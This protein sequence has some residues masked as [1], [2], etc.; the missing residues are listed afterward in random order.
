MNVRPFHA[1]PAS[2]GSQHVKG[3]T[4]GSAG[5]GF[6]QRSYGQ[7]ILFVI[8][9]MTVSDTSDLEQRLARQAEK[10]KQADDASIGEVIE[11]VKA[12]A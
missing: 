5:L 8:E 1:R 4:W 9:R 2:S 12:Y 3:H 6:N 10:A 7:S 11:Y